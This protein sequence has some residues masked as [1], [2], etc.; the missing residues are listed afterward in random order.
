[1]TVSR[2]VCHSYL[3]IFLHPSCHFPQNPRP[4]PTTQCVH[5][6]KAVFFL[7]NL[8]PTHII[9]SNGGFFTKIPNKWPGC[10]HP[11]FLHQIHPPMACRA[12]HHAVHRQGHGTVWWPWYP[13]R[14]WSQQVCD[15]TVYSTG[16]SCQICTNMA[17]YVPLFVVNRGSQQINHISTTLRSLE[18]L[19]QDHTPINITID[20]FVTTTG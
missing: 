14:Q 16:E 18:E 13:Y 19:T 6:P 3:I 4:I 20:R 15:S 7:Q 17:I 12:A 11:I 1:M 9:P 2:Y 8:H 5:P 10:H